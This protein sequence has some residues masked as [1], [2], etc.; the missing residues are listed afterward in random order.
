[1]LNLDYVPTDYYA[2][3]P[4]PCMGGWAKDVFDVMANGK[5]LPCHA[6]ESLPNVRFH[7]VRDTPLEEIWYRSEGFNLYRGTD[8]MREPCGTCE[9]KTI[10]LRRLPVPGAG[11]HGR[12]AQCRSSVRALA[13]SRRDGKAC[14]RGS[15]QATDALRLPQPAQCRRS[16]QGRAAAAGPCRIADGLSLSLLLR[17]RARSCVRQRALRRVEASL[18]YRPRRGRH[19]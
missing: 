9:R 1:M 15:G 18:P 12:R 8:W 19:A 10:D 6:A 5:M 3:Y 16:R 4:K 7:S 11:P 13:L 14:A 2:R 17:L